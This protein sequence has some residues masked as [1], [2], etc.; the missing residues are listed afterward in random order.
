MREGCPARETEPALRDTG[1][2]TLGSENVGFEQDL[3]AH[4]VFGECLEKP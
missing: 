1:E 4:A 3:P 2:P